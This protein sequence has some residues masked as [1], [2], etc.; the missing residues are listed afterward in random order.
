MAF[1]GAAPT[2]INAWPEVVSLD[3]TGRPDMLCPML[4]IWRQIK[5]LRCSLGFADYP[6]FMVAGIGVFPLSVPEHPPLLSCM[7]IFG[8]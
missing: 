1:P 7:V 8:F 4:L 5:V 3:A 2:Q 6:V